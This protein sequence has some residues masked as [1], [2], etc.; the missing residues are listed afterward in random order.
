M[1]LEDLVRSVASVESGEDYWKTQNELAGEVEAHELRIQRTKR[2]HQ[3]LREAI[4]QSSGYAVRNP[5]E[6]GGRLRHLQE[7]LSK[8]DAAGYHH[9]FARSV[10]LYLGDVLAYNVMPDHVVRLHGRNSSPGFFG[11]K[12]GR[13]QE[14]E[15]GRFL[16]RNGWTVLLHDL[17][18]CLRIGDLTAACPERGILSIE[19]GPGHNPRK[20]RQRERMNLLNRVLKE[21]IAGVRPEDL[22]THSLPTHLMEG[23]SHFG[24]NPAAF[25]EVA[26]CL[27]TGCKVVQ[28]EEGLI[29]AACARGCGIEDLVKELSPGE[30]GWRNYLVASFTDRIMGKFSWV[31]PIM[32]LPIPEEP[33]TSLLR[34]DFYFWVFLDVDHIKRRLADLAPSLTLSVE[35][36]CLQMSVHSEDAMSVLGPRPIE[37][38]QYGLATLESSLQMLA[39]NARVDLGRIVREFPIGGQAR[40]AH[41]AKPSQRSLRETAGQP[42]ELIW[43][44][45]RDSNPDTQ[46]QRL[47]SYH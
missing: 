11:G 40:T 25:V 12:S 26:A 45:G 44:G 36:D 28:P 15:V 21:D 30:R 17:T 10:I 2:R 6:Y 47:Q 18:H 9:R 4:N 31:P 29:Y 13:A 43:L 1:L 24:H 16:T 46:L 39:E 38:V 33:L 34:G 8:N 22:I 19:L 5:P 32:S 3:R 23:E 20:R 37:N 35:C 7:L 41:A 27:E 14:L 42:S